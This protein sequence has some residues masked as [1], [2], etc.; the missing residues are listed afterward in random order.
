MTKNKNKTY[1]VK[2]QDDGMS[3]KDRYE[4]FKDAK[5]NAVYKIAARDLQMATSARHVLSVSN[6]ICTICNQSTLYPCSEHGRGVTGCAGANAIAKDEKIN[7]SQRDSNFVVGIKTAGALGI[8]TAPCFLLVLSGSGM[9]PGEF[10]AAWAT[11]TGGVAAFGFVMG[12][13]L[14]EP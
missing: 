6:K 13:L 11:L 4:E 5:K 10:L 12:L 8:I 7:E 9:A 3:L 1:S 2:S 14:G